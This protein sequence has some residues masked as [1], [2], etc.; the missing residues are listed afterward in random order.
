MTI[1]FANLKNKTLIMDNIE[2][3][4]IISISGSTACGKSFLT[5]RLLNERLMSK[6]DY[7]FIFS[8]TSNLSRDWDDGFKETPVKSVDIYP[9]I[10]HVNKD[11]E[12]VAR[13]IFEKQG[14][15]KTSLNAASDSEKK[16]ASTPRTLLIFDDLGNNPIFRFNGFLDKVCISS[17]HYNISMLIIAQRISAIPRTLRLN[18][19]YFIVFNSFNYSEIERFLAEYVQ[20]KNKK[21]LL[22]K[23]ESIYNEPYN[24]IFCDNKTNS[25][26]TRLYKNGTELI[27]FVSG[28]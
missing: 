23:L 4:S 14:K 16:N 7:I 12:K 8:P 6:L 10:V 1:C 27:K 28:S 21:V 3:P 25:L 13:D 15:I 2:L 11:F 18:S 5:R 20:K 9:R 22:D 26:N 24:F 17:R 19:A